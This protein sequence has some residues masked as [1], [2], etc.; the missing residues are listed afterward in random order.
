MSV[1]APIPQFE[2]QSRYSIQ[3]RLVR[4]QSES[5][6]SELASRTEI[7]V[8]CDFGKIADMLKQTVKAQLVLYKALGVNK[9]NLEELQE[10]AYKGEHGSGGGIEEILKE[11]YEPDPYVQEWGRSRAYH[12]VTS[13]INIFVDLGLVRPLDL[14]TEATMS[15]EREEALI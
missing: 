9:E 4:L 7:L 13:S 14:T 3:E 5:I 12:Y 11:L 10:R 6:F 15:N 2:I 1:E 8:E